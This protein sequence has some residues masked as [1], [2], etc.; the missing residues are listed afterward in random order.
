ME[1]IYI[2]KNIKLYRTEMIKGQHDVKNDLCPGKNRGMMCK[3][4]KN[5]CLKLNDI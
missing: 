3:K 5:K 4:I 2:L 1:M